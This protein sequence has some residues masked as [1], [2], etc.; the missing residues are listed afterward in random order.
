MITRRAAFSRWVRQSRR[1]LPAVLALIACNGPAA[2]EPEKAQQ[3]DGV[4]L[5]NGIDQYERLSA[6]ENLSENDA[7][8]ALVVRSYVCAVV[9]LEKYLVLRADLLAAAVREAR[10]KKHHIN[11]EKLNG[12]AE[13]LPILVPLMRTK[14]A[15]DNPPCDRIVL[16]VREYLGKYPEMLTKDADVVIEKT[17]LDRYSKIDEP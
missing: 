8:D 1:W 16:S 10:K 3:R 7:N 6:H 12:M 17:L 5:R 9:D 4:W 13:A 2:D 11:P 15:T 14:F